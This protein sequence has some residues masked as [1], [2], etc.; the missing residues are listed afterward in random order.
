MNEVWQVRRKTEGFVQFGT[1][2]VRVRYVVFRRGNHVE[3]Y[4]P[5]ETVNKYGNLSSRKARSINH[6]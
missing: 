4:V 3:V 2:L 5:Q 6:F 1:F